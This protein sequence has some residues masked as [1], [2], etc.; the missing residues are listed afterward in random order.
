MSEAV[1]Y[2]ARLEAFHAD[3]RKHSLGPLWTDLTQMITREPVHHVQPYLWKWQTIRERALTAG[4]LLKPGKDSE[5]RVVYLQNPSLAKLGLVGYATYTLYAG[6]QLILPGEKAPPHRHSQGAIRFIIEGSGAYTCVN[7]ERIDMEPG[8]LIL[9]PPWTWHEHGHDGTEPVLWM[10]GLDVGLVKSFAA[11]FFNPYEGESYPASCP[12]N[13][14]THMYA[15]PG[16]VPVSKRVHKGYPSPLVHY[17][18]VHTRQ[19]LQ[20]LRQANPNVLDFNPHDGYALRYVNPSQG[21]PADARIGTQIQL[22]PAGVHL[23]AH[24]HVHSVVYHVA[25]GSGYT[26]IDGIRYDWA[27]GDFFIVPPW[28]WH[29]HVNTGEADACLFSIDDS[30]VVQLLGLE[31]EED[32]P[33]ESGQQAVTG[34]FQPGPLRD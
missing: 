23:R 27:Q 28:S 13:Y 30:D 34:V 25:S 31:H 12:A 3:L 24:R 11:S 20:R 5:R 15:A 26:V 18:W 17:P 6:I 7:G 22:L 1:T 29:E 9:T 21:G 33:S 14:S 16:L 10:D 19:A 4:S 32:H 2:E 8:D